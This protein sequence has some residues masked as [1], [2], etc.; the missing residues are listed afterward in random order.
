MHV[1]MMGRVSG[2]VG[3]SVHGVH[4]VGI[5]IVVPVLETV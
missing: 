2:I 5:G 4:G 1:G 3:V